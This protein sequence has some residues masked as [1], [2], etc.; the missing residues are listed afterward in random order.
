[1][2]ETP[3]G[4]TLADLLRERP[5]FHLDNG[6]PVSWH[7]REDV[8]AFIEAS[9]KP[10]DRTLE[11]G[12]GYS[13]VVFAAQGARH[14]CVS[15]NGPALE[16]IKNFCAA[17]GISTEHLDFALQDSEEFLPTLTDSTLDLALIDGGHGFPTPMVD[18][19][20][21]APHLR[22]GGLLVIDDT[23]LGPVRLLRD[24]LSAEEGWALERDFPYRTAVFRKT[25]AFAARE[26][27]DQPYALDLTLRFEPRLA[28][29]AFRRLK[30]ITRRQV[31]RTRR[32]SAPNRI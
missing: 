19:R 4:Y 32:K 28:V 13:T 21:I 24:F 16:K 29:K 17:H 2:P 8:L 3:S 11:T 5:A 12:E 15:P 7:L 30:W 14:T 31:D 23:Q 6:V 27:T 26:W 10:G 20:Y 9:V 1:M 25:A 22:V 18:W